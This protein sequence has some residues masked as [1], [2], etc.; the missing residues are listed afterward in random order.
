MLV[1]MNPERL[2]ELVSYY[3]KAENKYILVIDNT[4]WCYLSSEKQQE[5]LN[6]YDDDIID[7]DEVQ[8][9]FS[10]TLTFYKFDTQT[11]AIDTARSWFPLLKELEDTDYF[12][13][14]YV[15]TPTG[16]IPYTNKVAAS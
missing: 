11:V 2:Y 12:V 7:E 8:E 13:E 4:D 1:S 16:A 9:I 5:V 6:F 15:V 14:A 3:A 10:N